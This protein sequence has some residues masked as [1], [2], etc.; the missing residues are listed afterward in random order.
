MS[1]SEKLRTAGKIRGFGK[2]AKPVQVTI[3][4]MVG[5]NQWALRIPVAMDLR[6]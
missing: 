1:P 3:S 4:S 5:G 6:V 2:A